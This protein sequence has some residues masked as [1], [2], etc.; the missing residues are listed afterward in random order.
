MLHHVG[1]RV[2]LFKTLLELLGRVPITDVAVQATL[3]GH[4][5]HITEVWI[6]ELERMDGQTIANTNMLDPVEP[7]LCRIE[8]EALIAMA[9][10]HASV[11][12]PALQ[13]LLTARSLGRALAFSH[14]RTVQMI[15][16]EVQR[17]AD[18]APVSYTHLTLPTILRV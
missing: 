8:S 2:N 16:G 4:F 9:H 14:E 17:A 12:L 1:L 18:L 11:R 6:R 5:C 10:P 15:S 3:L 7:Y 13:L